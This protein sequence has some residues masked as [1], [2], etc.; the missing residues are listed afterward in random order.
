MHV[1]VSNVIH[2]SMRSVMH[3]SMRSVMHGSAVLQA[4][5]ASAG[6]SCIATVAAAKINETLT[7]S[8]TDSIKTS[9][10]ESV[11]HWI[12]ILEHDPKNFGNGTFDLQLSKYGSIS[13]FME[14]KENRKLS[15]ELPNYYSARFVHAVYKSHQK[16]KTAT[17]KEVLFISLINELLPE[18][19][20]CALVITHDALNE[21]LVKSFVKEEA[22][23][24]QPKAVF[25]LRTMTAKEKS[26]MPSEF[27]SLKTSS[28]A[29]Y[30][31][32]L[33]ADAAELQRV[34]LVLYKHKALNM[35]AKFVVF[36]RMS[37]EE[38]RLMF[39][40]SSPV[41]RIMNVLLVTP[42]SSSPFDLSTH[43]FFSASAR[44]ELQPLGFWKLRHAVAAAQGMKVSTFNFPPVVIWD[45]SVP[46]QC[47]NSRSNSQCADGL[48]IRILNAIAEALNFT[49]WLQVPKDGELWGGL[50]KNGSWTGAFGEVNRGDVDVAFANYFITRQRLNIMDMTTLHS[51]DYACFI[52]PIPPPPSQY[53]V[54]VRPFHYIVW[55]CLILSLLLMSPFLLFTARQAPADMRFGN[56]GKSSMSLWGIQLTQSLHAEMLPSTAPLRLW[57]IFFY[58]A[59]FIVSVAY[60]SSLFSYILVPATGTPVNSLRQLLESGLKWG[61]RDSGDWDSWFSDSKDPITRQIFEGFQYVNSIDSGI[62]K[63]LNGDF[64]FMNSGRQVLRYLLD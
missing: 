53:T 13:E 22:L 5:L 56:L 23:A 9:E 51:I 25:N 19:D 26:L 28:C 43:H 1:S 44:I 12:E 3:V 21:Q 54:V 27:H 24:F 29:N 45:P 4:V 62:K 7:N 60:R 55:I 42:T 20:N 10:L 8:Q 52:T 14:F 31:L 35:T 57:F 40:K 59:S 49:A 16:V 6:I 17:A 36:S 63:V 41:D 18:F 50:L 48:E 47:K 30:Y 15:T 11:Q 58:M 2:V 34:L 64:A 46:C 33:V 38:D 39:L 61:V 32:M 37:N